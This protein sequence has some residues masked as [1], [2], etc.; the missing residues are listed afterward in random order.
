VARRGRLA[1]VP[2]AAQPARAVNPFLS[3][4]RRSRH[5][6]AL[7]LVLFW[8]TGL[9]RATR[10][11][12]GSDLRTIG[13]AR[14]ALEND[15]DALSATEV[16]DLYALIVGMAS[17]GIME[18]EYWIYRGDILRVQDAPIPASILDP[19][20]RRQIAADFRASPI[21]VTVA[22]LPKIIHL[23]ANTPIA[24]TRG[25]QPDGTWSETSPLGGKVGYVVFV[26]G[27]LERFEGRIQGKLQA[28]GT[29]RPTSDIREALPPGTRIGEY[30]PTKEE[31]RRGAARLAEMRR[32]E[33]ARRMAW[34]MAWLLPVIFAAVTGGL[35]WRAK[36]RSAPE[37]A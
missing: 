13:G 3:I 10:P 17:K 37:P 27:N 20:N 33:R 26:G 30:Q 32:Q 19:E 35:W 14:L 8:A 1:N 28:Y 31:L 21:A 9:A 2:A 4:A 12:H 29:D 7:G 16:T 5:A 22:L 24:W 25:L 34:L 11:V 15:G 36:R 18:P 6:L 23:P